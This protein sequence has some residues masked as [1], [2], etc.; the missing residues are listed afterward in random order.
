M[1]KAIPA[2]RH[3]SPSYTSSSAGSD[4]HPSTPTSPHNKKSYTKPSPTQKT[5]ASSKTNVKTETKPSIKSPPSGSGSGPGS[6]PSKINRWSKEDKLNLL[7]GVIEKANLSRAV[8][9]EIAMEKFVGRSS[10]QV[11]DQWR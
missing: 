1:P 3:P 4:I 8:F 5:I 6:S 11:Y 10:A 9:G 2:P 7:L